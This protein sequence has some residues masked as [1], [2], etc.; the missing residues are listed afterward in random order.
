MISVDSIQ[1]FHNDQMETAK[2][3]LGGSLQGVIEGPLMKEFN[4]LFQDYEIQQKEP[5]IDW[6]AIESL[7]SEM[8]KAYKDLPQCNKADVKYMLS[9][10]VVVKLN[11]GLGTSMG[12]K[13][14]KSAIEVKNGLT[15]LDLQVR[16][17]EYLNKLYD[18]DVPLVLMNSFNTEEET[19]KIIRKYAGKRVTIKCFKQTCFPRILSDTFT[20][21]AKEPFNESRKEHWYPPGHGDVYR[22]LQMSGLLDQLLQK[23]GEDDAFYMGDEEDE[24][25]NVLAGKEYMFMSNIDN[26]GATVDLDILNHLMANDIGFCMEVTNKT[27]ADIKGG[28]LIK[29][30]KTTK[31]LEVAQVP[32]R[33]LEE[34]KNIKK[35]KIFNTNNLWV[36]LEAMSNLLE[37][38]ALKMEV[39]SNK[40]FV[41]GERVLQ[42]ETAAGSAIR[43]F[44]R[45]IGINVPRS[46][47]LP[48]KT[49]SDLMLIQSNLFKLAHGTLVKNPE[50]MT[51]DIP[52]IKLGRNFTTVAEYQQ[53]VKSSP[54][55]IDLDHLTISGD[56]Y[57]GKS[58]NLMGTVIIVAEEGKRIDLP[59][60]SELENK[61]LA[62]NL[63]IL[64]H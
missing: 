41:D 6:E 10:L 37:Q 50:R 54:S 42:L 11:G 1:N 55:L 64:D 15:F 17:I 27:R 56:V 7:D 53:R 34:F 21:M 47:F 13:G 60:R 29:Y 23:K 33:Y 12:C 46:R 26:L 35:F 61:V 51:D 40:K 48:V 4:N 32:D 49:T 25:E 9:K 30:K 62:G 18:V 16:Q 59:D 36:K 38:N 58:M 39:I 24:D 2:H 44:D 20:S 57:L 19:Q 28:T 22:S 8:L 43:F 3:L 5:E 63:R 31:L 45:A 14:P 52:A